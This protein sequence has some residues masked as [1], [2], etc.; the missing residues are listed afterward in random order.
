ML[1][2]FKKSK[3]IFQNK[4]LY[5]KSL[6]ELPIYNWWQFIATNDYGYLLKEYNNNAFNEELAI[7]LQNKMISKIGLSKNYKEKLKQEIEL[8]QLINEYVATSKRT[9]ITFIKIK[10]LEIAD[11]KKE[12]LEQDQHETL[13]IIEKKMGFQINT[14]TTPVLTFYGYINL[15]D[16]NR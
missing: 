7:K 9:L 2:F 15:Q 16:G 6:G 1:R 11:L 4:D 13:A 3:Q 10:E 8:A 12:E 14:R 5:F